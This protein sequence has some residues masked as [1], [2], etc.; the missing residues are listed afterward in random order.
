MRI[1]SYV[2]V[3]LLVVACGTEGDAA[4]ESTT[5]ATD[6]SASIP[7]R[8]TTTESSSD[9]SLP[10]GLSGDLLAE[11][12]EDAAERTSATMSEIEVTSIEATTFN[13]AALGCPEPGRLYAQVI[14]PGFIV[15]VD[16]GSDEL[17]YRVAEDSEAF[18]VCG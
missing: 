10:A 4:D 15:L 1:F 17:D 18:R 2:T 12:V 8:T 13:D 7:R 16:A 5:A 6:G 14:T 11:I 9:T 3:L